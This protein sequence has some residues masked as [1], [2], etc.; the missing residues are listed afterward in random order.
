MRGKGLRD[1]LRNRFGDDR[2]D[3]E[4]WIPERVHITGSARHIRGHIH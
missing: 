2:I 3:S 4:V 1:V